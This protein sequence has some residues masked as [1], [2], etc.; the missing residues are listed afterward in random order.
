MFISEAAARSIVQEIKEVS[1]YDVNIM[2]ETGIIF[3]STDSARVGQRHEGAYRILEQGLTRLVVEADSAR[4]GGDR[5]GINLPIQ[6]EGRTVG[7]IG[8]TCVQAQAQKAA[9]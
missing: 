2:D 3:A 1:G 8:I 7:V 9:Q 6:L 4:P 5:Q